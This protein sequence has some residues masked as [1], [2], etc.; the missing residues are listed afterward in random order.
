MSSIIRPSKSLASFF[1]FWNKKAAVIA[2]TRP[3]IS[4]KKVIEMACS[5]ESSRIL[6]V[7]GTRINEYS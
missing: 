7:P 2:S 1:I 3:F 6:P 5:E 4:S